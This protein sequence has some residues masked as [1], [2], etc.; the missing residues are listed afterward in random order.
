M[1]EGIRSGGL[2]GISLREQHL[3]TSKKTHTSMSLFSSPGSSPKQVPTGSISV[4]AI[5]SVNLPYQ[6]LIVSIKP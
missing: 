6:L 3:N 5:V 2:G 1:Q 4:A